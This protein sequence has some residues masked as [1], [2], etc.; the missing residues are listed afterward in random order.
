[1]S[2]SRGATPPGAADDPRTTPLPTEEQTMQ[3]PT[4][5]GGTPEPDDLTAT[6][7]LTT[8]G[9]DGT[10]GSD[11][12]D[13]TAGTAGTGAEPAST[14]TT[15][16]SDRLADTARLDTARP[17]DTERLTLDERLG[18]APRDDVV[19]RDDPAPAAPLGAT[20]PA[21]EAPTP[22]TWSA[23]STGAT[24]PDAAPAP[25][26]VEEPRGVRVGTVVWGLVVAAVGV[27]LVAWASG[28]VFDVE[29]AVIGLVAAAGVALLLGSLLAPRRRRSS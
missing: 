7:P 9:S 5:A 29:L 12:T 25:V 22:P 17:A 16:G 13:G 21:P 27:G 23:A 8:P 18:L 4:P 15:E 28:L 1:M 11:S 20:A 3:T 10:D 2:P 26:A 19:V 14:R 24:A 6:T